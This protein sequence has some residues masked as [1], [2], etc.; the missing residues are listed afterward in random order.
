MVRGRLWRLANPAL[1]PNRRATL[2]QK[3]MDARRAVKAAKKNK[4][5][6]A[7]DVAH[8]QV[9]TIK[10]ALGERGPV[11]WSD[12]TP[13]LTRYLVKNTG[14]AEWYAQLMESEMAKRARKAPWKKGNPRKKTG[15]R[16]K[17]LSTARKAKA[18]RSAKKAGRPYPNLVDNMNA[19]KKKRGA[20]KKTG[21]KK[22]RRS[23]K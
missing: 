2:V 12:G 8:Q 23:S 11:W 1:R 3:L 13:D 16:S 4:H 10:T 22:K 15:K 6:K 9:N 19:A 14:Y 7:E 17:K 18:K 5:R 21:A 20:K